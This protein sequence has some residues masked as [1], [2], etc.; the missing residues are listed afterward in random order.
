[1]QMT[2]ARPSAQR[3]LYKHVTSHV[4]SED[5][6]FHEDSVGPGDPLPSFDLPTTDG[7]RFRTADITGIKPVLLITGSL[8]CPMTA[9][10]NPV[11]KQLHA[12][13]G[14]RIDFV[15]LHVREAHP[16]ERVDQPRTS[17]EKM[18]H[19]S[20]LKRRDALPWPVAV[21]D[22]EGTVHRA[23]D[24]KPNAAF[25][26]DRSGRIVFRS[27]W[28]GDE[29]GLRQ[30]L[31][32]VA[33]GERPAEAESQRRLVP[34]AAGIGMMGEMIERSGPRAKSDMWRTA[35]P[36]AAIAWTADWFRPLPPQ[37]RPAAALATI[38]VAAGATIGLARAAAH[39]NGG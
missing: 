7:G 15:M 36:M 3:Y 13:F 21:D 38:G 34:M 26:T 16:G 27:L 5:M 4:L 1:M 6:A 24:G 10:S 28:A 39:R 25:L 19:A 29:Y 9:S 20:E 17:A 30:A 23:F 33:R 8:T 11:L 32:C 35:P 14:N 18:E 22:V 12:E 37:W 2:Q 31:E